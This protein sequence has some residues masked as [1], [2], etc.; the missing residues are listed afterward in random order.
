MKNEDGFN[1]AKVTFNQSIKER[2]GR[3]RERSGRAGL[4]ELGGETKDGLVVESLSSFTDEEHE[5][6]TLRGENEFVGGLKL[7]KVDLEE[8]L[9]ALVSHK[10]ADDLILG[11]DVLGLSV[12]LDDG[13]QNL[14]EFIDG[15]G[16]LQLRQ[17]RLHIVDQFVLR[18]VLANSAV[19]L[20]LADGYLL[21]HLEPKVQMTKDHQ[22]LQQL[23]FI[24]IHL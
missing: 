9:L 10:L 17:E 23:C 12:D 13:L 5:I 21:H 6:N 24:N 8:D 7:A 19:H 22:V 15:R 18:N 2:A 1:S 11:L 14:K 4:D 3:L 16:D 20:H